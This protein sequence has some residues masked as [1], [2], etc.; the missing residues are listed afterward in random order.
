MKIVI[1]PELMLRLQSYAAAIPDEFSGFGFCERQGGNIYVYD[2][3]LLNKGSYTYTEIAPAAIEDPPR[4]APGIDAHRPS[5]AACEIRKRE[6]GSRR[7]GKPSSRSDRIEIGQCGMIGRQQQMIAI[8]DHHTEHGIVVG[9]ASPPGL[10]GGL[11]HHHAGAA[12]CQ[13]HRRSPS[14]PGPHS[15]HTPHWWNR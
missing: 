2:F 11:V 5:L 7:A 9:S 12:R 15:P 8:V 3:V 14:R 4:Q 10:T 6:L 13:S 1:E